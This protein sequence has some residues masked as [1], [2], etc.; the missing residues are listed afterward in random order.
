MLYT[1]GFKN[2]WGVLLEQ[3][4]EI[5]R[6]TDEQEKNRKLNLTSKYKA[7]LEAQ[8]SDKNKKAKFEFQWDHDPNDQK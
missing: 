3:Q 6:I 7:E 8:L 1:L 5:Q 4:A 2:Q